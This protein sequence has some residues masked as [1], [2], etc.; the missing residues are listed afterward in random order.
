MQTISG[1]SNILTYQFGPELHRQWNRSI[2]LGSMIDVKPG[3]GRDCSWAVAFSGA[4]ADVASEGE[5]VADSEL[6]NDTSEDAHLSW[7]TYRSSFQISE[8]A[9]DA[10][11]SSNGDPEVLMDQFGELVMN[12]G[13]AIAKKIE[14]DLVTG[15]GTRS[16]RAQTIN[17]IVGFLGGAIEASGAYAGLDPAT[18]TEWAANVY[19]NSSVDRPLT[20]EL[21]AQ[22][23]RGVFDDT[24][25]QFRGFIATT[26]A[27]ADKYEA[28]WAQRLQTA[29]GGRA[30]IGAT[31]LAWRGRPIVTSAD[32]TSGSA[33]LIDP[34][35][36]EIRFLPFRL[37]KYGTTR[38]QAL[39]FMAEVRRVAGTADG[40]SFNLTDLPLR[41]AIL[42]KEGDS[43]K[44]ELRTTVQLVV[45]R[46]NRIARIGDIAE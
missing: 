28:L 37:E 27:I 42:G 10:A 25:V 21:L 4:V 35:E 5:D 15:T 36:V 45:K 1:L 8:Q 11:A 44:A 14:A 26:Q 38:E 19:E 24:G 34:G 43:V 6:T 40:K 3:A 30:D 12:A 39:R 29:A 18:Y 33:L 20:G 22:A 16:L 17:T 9:I 13:A 31:D 23:A 2:V 32:I 41:I 7:A 46:R